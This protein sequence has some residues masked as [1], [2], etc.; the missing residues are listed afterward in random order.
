MRVLFEG[1][2]SSQLRYPHP[3]RI[4]KLLFAL[5]PT[6]G[7][8]RPKTTCTLKF[9]GPCSSRTLEH[10]WE[11]LPLSSRGCYYPARVSLLS[12]RAWERAGNFRPLSGGEQHRHNSLL[13]WLRLLW[14][15]PHTRVI[16]MR[17][18]SSRLCFVFFWRG[19]HVWF[20]TSDKCTSGL[21]SNRVT[22]VTAGPEEKNAWEGRTQTWAPPWW[23]EKFQETKLMRTPNVCKQKEW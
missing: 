20:P 23:S 9:L 21:S 22:G 10:E 5:L 2:N 4:P 18:H 15:G 17:C 8:G 1:L 16:F 14:C 12:T 6:R 11:G 13:L 3:D 7:A 19:W